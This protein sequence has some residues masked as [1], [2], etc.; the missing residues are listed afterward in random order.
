MVIGKTPISFDAAGLEH[1]YRPIQR[2]L[3]HISPAPVGLERGEISR[4]AAPRKDAPMTEAATLDPASGK[5]LGVL[6]LLTMQRRGGDA[7]LCDLDD[8]LRE[9]RM[10][11]IGPVVL[12][13]ELGTKRP[14]EIACYITEDSDTGKPF[15]PDPA[16]R[17]FLLQAESRA[18]PPDWQLVPVRDPRLPPSNWRRGY[19]WPSW[20]HTIR[21]CGRGW[22]R[23]G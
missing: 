15:K 8:R 20:P 16:R 23:P 17:L 11:R 21:R 19:C 12:I 3:V 5:L 2:R 22:P 1:D 6:T 14:R 7:I 9:L 10:A 13:E 4:D 18:M